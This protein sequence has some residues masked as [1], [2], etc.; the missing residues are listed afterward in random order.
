SGP[1]A[2]LAGLNLSVTTVRRQKLTIV[3]VPEILANAPFVIDEDNGAHWRPAP[4]GAQLVFTDPT[5][6]P[7]DPAWDVP[8]SHDFAFELLDPSSEHNVARACPFWRSVWE[9]GSDHWLPQAGQY[10]YTH[11][12]KP[13]LGPTGVPGLN[14]NLGYSGHG[15]M[16]SAGGSR[17]VVDLLLGK[18][19]PADNPFRVDRPIAS[20][21]FDVI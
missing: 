20:R 7:T 8:V 17:R 16:G 5:T 15:V 11:D 12:H 6:P 1:V 2:R 18:L 4:N 3:D 13:F 9:R 10:T 14:L 19:S 21:A